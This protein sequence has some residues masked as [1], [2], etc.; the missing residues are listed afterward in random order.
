MFIGTLGHRVLV[1]QTEM[2]PSSSFCF[3]GDLYFLLFKAP[4][5]LTKAPEG[6]PPAAASQW[7]ETTSRPFDSYLKELLSFFSDREEGFQP[8]GALVLVLGSI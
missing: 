2:N 1:D 3:A 8:M 6:H 5:I 7:R 4:N